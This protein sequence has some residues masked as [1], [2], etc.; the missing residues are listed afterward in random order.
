MAKI[1]PPAWTLPTAI[2]TRV[3]DRAGRQRAMAADGHLL[4]VLHET[5][6]ADE[7]DRVAR[8][9]WRD[10]KGNW[11]SNT[12][13][14]GIQALRKHLEEYSARVDLLENQLSHAKRADELSE[15]LSH[16]GP[17]HRAIR[18][19][20]AA[21]QQAREAIPGD[22]DIILCRDEAGDI[23]R[24]AELLHYDAQNELDLA[25]VRQSEEQTRRTY[26][27]AVSAHRLNLLAAFFFPLATLSALFGM[28]IR[29]G[30]ESHQTL[31]PF[32]IVMLGGIGIGAVLTAMIMSRPSEGTKTRTPAP[33]P[34]ERPRLP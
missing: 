3:G 22:R 13:G 6:E 21:L 7:D 27:M 31:W 20:H 4:L 19:L 9:F 23:E 1:L 24:A 8:L 10:D 25:V 32:W 28:N 30:L 17:I 11:K 15:V 2:A 34:H 12:L 16:I 5:P 29:H 18:H 33:R 14:T 26:E